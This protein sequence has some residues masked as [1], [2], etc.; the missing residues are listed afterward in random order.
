VL[1]ALQELVAEL[2]AAESVE[3]DRLAILELVDLVVDGDPQA[4]QEGSGRVLPE[5]HQVFE[6][7]ADG[8]GR[9][10]WTHGRRQRSHV[11]GG[12]LAPIVARNN[13]E[14]TRSRIT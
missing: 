5:A 3:P 6:L 11:K 10:G 1:Q 13:G 14:C 12:P 4:R 2:V 8:I 9:A 7:H